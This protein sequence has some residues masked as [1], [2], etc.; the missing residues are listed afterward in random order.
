MLF[1][2]HS[3]TGS[4]VSSFVPKK[5]IYLGRGCDGESCFF[6]PSLFMLL[7]SRSLFIYSLEI[8][9][10]LLVTFRSYQLTINKKVYCQQLHTETT[11]SSPLWCQSASSMAP[12]SYMGALSLRDSGQ[13]EVP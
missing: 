9:S 4:Y 10:V 3:R 11:K 8:T 12:G 5:E 6:L 13:A 2:E 7:I 1:C